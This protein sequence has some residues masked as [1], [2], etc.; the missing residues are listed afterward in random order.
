MPSTKAVRKGAAKSAV[1]A[2]PSLRDEAKAMYRRAVLAAAEQV[3]AAQGIRGARIQDIAKLARVSVGTVYNHFESKE[4]IV[5]ALREEHERELRVVAAEDPTVPSGF[6]PQFRA[7]MDRL[8]KTVESHRAFFAF[9]IQEGFLEPPDAHG[10]TRCA[11]HEAAP[12]MLHERMRTLLQQGIDE[13]AVVQQDL[14]LLWRFVAGAFESVILDALQESETDLV[15]QGRVVCDLCLR[16]MR[17]PDEPRHATAPQKKP[18]KA[19]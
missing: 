14:G 10:H 3:F 19:R 11:A 5:A 15:A 8:I 1:A 13:G 18:G 17:P 12:A 6:E 2:V 7:L 4:D 16:G 9:A